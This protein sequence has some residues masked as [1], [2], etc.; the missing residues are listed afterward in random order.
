MTTDTYRVALSQQSP[1]TDAL[2]SSLSASI[3]TLAPVFASNTNSYTLTVPFGAASF[4]LTPTADDAHAS[5]ITVRQDSGTPA[6]VA[7]GAAS[8]GAACRLRFCMW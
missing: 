7:S 3:G 6:T 4:T 5:S 2:L 8:S 1:S